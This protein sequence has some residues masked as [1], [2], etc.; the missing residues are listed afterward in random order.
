MKKIE[1]PFRFVEGSQSVACFQF[2][3]DMQALSDES[4][5]V[6]EFPCFFL[7]L[8]TGEVL[9]VS[10]E[11]SCGKAIRYENSESWLVEGNGWWIGFSESEG[12]D[13]IEAS[14]EDLKLFLESELTAS[15][16]SIVEDVLELSRKNDLSE[17]GIDGLYQKYIDNEDSPSL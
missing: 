3:V 2:P 15:F 5:E 16:K 17:L 7:D 12:A 6:S 1:L 13:F 4:F 10:Q 8:R 11:I 9:G 14:N